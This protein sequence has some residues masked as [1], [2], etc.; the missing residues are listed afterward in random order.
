MSKKLWN[1]EKKFIY[2]ECI[3]NISKHMDNTDSFTAFDGSTAL[4]VAFDLDKEE[5]LNDIMDFR[6]K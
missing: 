5:T 2:D 3:E 4:A 6:E 1:K